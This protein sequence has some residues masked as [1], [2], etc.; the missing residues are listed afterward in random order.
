MT[1]L[2]ST[3]FNTASSNASTTPTTTTRL[4]GSLGSD[5]QIKLG[6]LLP[7][8]LPLTERERAL[9][10]IRDLKADVDNLTSPLPTATTPQYSTDTASTSHLRRSAAHH[11]Q[12]YDSKVPRR[13][14]SRRRQGGVVHAGGHL[15]PTTRR[16][17][18]PGT[19]HESR[20]Q[21]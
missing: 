15:F 7:P 18:V 17:A 5:R 1:T 10:H 20:K 13:T 21:I 2:R 16:R 6:R 4:G 3:S 12:T 14:L 19:K 11:N 8:P 9:A